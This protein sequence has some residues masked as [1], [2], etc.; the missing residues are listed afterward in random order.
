MT[1]DPKCL[2]EAEVAGSYPG[3]F[4]P[5]RQCDEVDDE[6]DDEHK[7]DDDCDPFSWRGVSGSVF[8]MMQTGGLSP[9]TLVEIFPAPVLR[10]WL[11]L[12]ESIIYTY[13]YTYVRIYVHTYVRTYVYVRMYVRTYVYVCLSVYIRTYVRTYVR[14]YVDGVEGGYVRTY[15]RTYGDYEDCDNTDG[16]GDDVCFC[17]V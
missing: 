7:D 3:R 4:E 15:V 12:S 17:D 2:L 10:K 8:D 14:S 13:V 1:P 5:K 9:Q 6:G 11:V 16:D